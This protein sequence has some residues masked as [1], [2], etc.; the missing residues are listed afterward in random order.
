M[1][2][3]ELRGG[4]SARPVILVVQEGKPKTCIAIQGNS[5]KGRATHVEFEV[6]EPKTESEVPN[7]TV[8]RAKATCLCCGTVLPPDRV[9]AQLVAQRG[10][11]EVIFDEKGK[12][13]GGARLLAVVKLT[14]GEQG[15][16][17]RLPAQRDYEAVWKAQKRLKEILNEWKRKG[18]KGLC[19]VP[20][21]PTPA[22]G[23]SGAGRAFSVQKYGMMTF[24][25]LFTRRQNLA[26]LTFAA[27]IDRENSLSRSIALVLGKLIDLS[28]AVCPWEPIAECPRNVLSNGRIKPSWDFAEGVTISDSSGSFGVCVNNF[29][30]GVLSVR[31][32]D[33]SG[34]T[35]VAAAQQSPL[36]DESARLWFTDPP[37]YDA[38]PYADLSDMFFVWFKRCLARD[39]FLRDPYDTSNSLTPKAA[40]AIQDEARQFNGKKQGQDL[41]RGDHGFSIC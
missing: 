22:G 36:P 29:V 38:I 20:D 9:R 18:S 3:S 15:R 21:E 28:N 17:Y 26:L 6:F 16:H 7:G 37:Y 10:G 25:D 41:F 1:R 5:T 31:G 24:G 33:R 14:P 34:T 11:A 19:P 23:G 40:E 32:I 27:Q 12:R 35:E 8:T 39:T 2:I 4:D 30:S 13:V